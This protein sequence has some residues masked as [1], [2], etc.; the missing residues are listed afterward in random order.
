[1]QHMQALLQSVIKEKPPD[2]YT[3]MIRVL[4]NSRSAMEGATY[5]KTHQPRQ[6]PASA[7]R[8]GSTPK[9]AQS[10][11]IHQDAEAT[12]NFEENLVF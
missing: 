4:E 9:M 8:T 6:R 2:P 12:T 5:Q 7:P 1:M 11:K 3:F 10:T